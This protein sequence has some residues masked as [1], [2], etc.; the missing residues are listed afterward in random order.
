MLHNLSEA[1]TACEMSVCTLSTKDDAS[2][3]SV[4][5]DIKAINKAVPTRYINTPYFYIEKKLY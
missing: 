5:H 2:S 1:F 4:V 3:A